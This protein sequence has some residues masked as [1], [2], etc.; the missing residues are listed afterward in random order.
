MA[1]KK[2]F[3]YKLPNKT[4]YHNQIKVEQLQVVAE[5]IH[6]TKFIGARGKHL[7]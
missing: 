5:G 3:S 7:V 6:N 2:A 1:E 4:I